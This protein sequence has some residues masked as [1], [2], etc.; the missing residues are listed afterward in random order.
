MNIS[1]IKNELF[2]YLQ[3]CW[4]FTKHNIEKE[5]SPFVEENVLEKYLYPIEQFGA[6]IQDDNEE[7]VESSISNSIILYF[8]YLPNNILD[9]NHIKFNCVPFKLLMN[10]D[11]WPFDNNMGRSYKNYLR[12]YKLFEDMQ[13]FDKIKD[14]LKNTP[15]Y[16]EL[17]KASDI[18]DNL[19][20]VVMDG[21]KSDI[22]YIDNPLLNQFFDEDDTFKENYNPDPIDLRDVN[23]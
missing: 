13:L 6:L 12:A 16:D 3:K 4:D 20:D 1:I 19:S 11:E 15:F 18:W 2:Y 23:I 9:H 21:T 10:F 5:Y 14:A 17:N 22:L 7:T 8:D